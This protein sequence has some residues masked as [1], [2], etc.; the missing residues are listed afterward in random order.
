[1]FHCDWHVPPGGGSL[2]A[3]PALWLNERLLRVRD[4]CIPHRR[5]RVDA[6]GDGHLLQIAD[7]H[8]LEDSLIVDWALIAN[9]ESPVR[10]EHGCK[11]LLPKLPKLATQAESQLGSG[12]GCGL[13]QIRPTRATRY[14]QP[15]PAELGP[16]L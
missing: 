4:A 5:L 2:P 7:G 6:M 12:R 13:P 15:L 16:V 11:R 8:L 3:A 14:P 1:M 10:S 9:L